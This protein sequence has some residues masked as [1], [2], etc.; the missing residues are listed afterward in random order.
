[1]SE[2]DVGGM[3]VEAE[4]S[5]QYSSNAAVWQMTERQSDKM[6]SDMEMHMRQSV[7]EFLHVE[8]LHPLTFI[9]AFG[10]FLETKKWMWAQWDGGWCVS[11]AMTV[12]W[13]TIRVLDGHA[14]LSHHEMKRISISLSI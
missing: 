1:M 9:Y 7:V 5:H 6:A 13:K 8:K 2:A 12:I 10:I 4:P 3:A 11:A 14:Q